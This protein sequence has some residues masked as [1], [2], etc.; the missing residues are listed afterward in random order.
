V[1]KRTRLILI[2]H[3]ETEW[4]K[5]LRFQG[6]RDIPLSE[7]GRE[8][9]RKIARRLAC[10]KIDTAYASDLSRALETAKAIADYHKLE[11]N[12]VPELREINF[13]YWEGLTHK[14][15]DSKYPES[16]AQWL[17]NPEET[18]IP[19][20]E[21]MNDV[22]ERCRVGISGILADNPNKDVLV[23]A[24]GGV[25][26]IVVAQAL[27]IELNN[28]WKF[29][30]DNVSLNII[31]YYENGKAIVNVLNDTSHLVGC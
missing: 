9:A 8:Q 2:R 13:G 18:K 22:A 3:G 20:G 10:E 25:L 31:D 29:R 7:D 11:V 6:H 4:N 21:S 30:L 5:S 16:M 12:M 15:I 17:S 26:R 19:G 1:K 14:E 24:H 28:Y 23:A 27:G